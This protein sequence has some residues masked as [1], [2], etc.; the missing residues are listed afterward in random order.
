MS[1]YFKRV[2]VDFEDE[3]MAAQG[4]PYLM[5]VVAAV[6]DLYQKLV[7]TN[8]GIH[9]TQIKSARTIA[10]EYFYNQSASVA[11]FC[12][13][14]PIMLKLVLCLVVGAEITEAP[15]F[16]DGHYEVEIFWEDDIFIVS[17]YN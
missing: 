16:G 12:F 2:S 13:C 4:V 7:Q 9:V 3:L 5:R 15:P 1:G 6:G 8:E 14:I 10:M 11:V 17:K